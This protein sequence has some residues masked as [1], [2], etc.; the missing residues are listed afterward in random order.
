LASRELPFW[1]PHPRPVANPQSIRDDA[2]KMVGAPNM[3]QGGDE[4][5]ASGSMAR[6]PN[7]RP[8]ID[9]QPN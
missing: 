4:Q 3:A 8:D 9:E 7:Q 6:N 2:L 1:V 5:K